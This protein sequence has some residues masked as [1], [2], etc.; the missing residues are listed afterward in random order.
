MFSGTKGWCL[1]PPGTV[2]AGL[3]IPIPYVLRLVQPHF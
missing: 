3:L 2:F 1:L